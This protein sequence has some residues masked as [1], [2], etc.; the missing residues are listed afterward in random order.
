MDKK[1][2][3]EMQKALKEINLMLEDPSIS[4]EDRQKL[5]DYAGAI[6]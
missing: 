1:T 3:D 5:D 4:K 2:Y 6:S